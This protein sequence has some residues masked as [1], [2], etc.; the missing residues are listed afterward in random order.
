MMMVDQ[1]HDYHVLIDQ[2]ENDEI[3]KMLDNVHEYVNF[4]I[5]V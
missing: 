1:D 4:Y 5:V 3:E 2:D